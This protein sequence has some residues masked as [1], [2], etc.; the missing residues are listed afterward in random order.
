MNDKYN[1]EGKYDQCDYIEY[2][3]FSVQAWRNSH[4]HAETTRHDVKLFHLG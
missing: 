3:K 4:D 2:F 1:L